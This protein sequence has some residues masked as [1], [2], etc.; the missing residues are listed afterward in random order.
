M[1]CIEW[2]EK[3][4]GSIDGTLRPDEKR[5][6]EAH[7]I[8]CPACRAQLESLQSLRA[9][10]RQL[11]SEIT[12]S[13]DLWSDIELRLSQPTPERARLLFASFHIWR[14][15]CGIALVLAAVGLWRW[16]ALRQPS[17]AWQI[18][19]VEGTPQINTRGFSGQANLRI[20]DWLETDA[21]ARAKVSVG[22]IGQVVVA[23]NSRVRMINA[24]A[25]NH[26]LE[27]ARGT[28]SALIWA[29]PRLFFVNTPSAVAVD[30]GC[31]YTLTVDD[32]GNGAL[33]V[34]SGYVAL[35]HD[36]RETIISAGQMCTTRR[37]AGPGTP[38]VDDA[39]P[40]LRRALDRFDF[41]HAPDALSEILTHVR[42]ADTLTLFSL[43][44]RVAPSARGEVFDVLARH[45]SPPTEV[46]K[47]GIVE[48]NRTMLDAWSRE[49]GLRGFS[50]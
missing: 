41:E 39:P 31:A 4:N 21:S 3:L 7:L 44:E 13:R 28:M 35:Q 48:G 11:P 9:A 25:E 30:L 19:A 43:L 10:T 5:A 15:A 32:H 1:N 24:S 17:T 23:P 40:A 14:I 2:K 46:T 33:H 16:T 37:D 49:L 6:L 20:G 22:T 27:L 26:R 38:F 29:P 34:T 12:P 8:V 47:V 45:Q 50:N 18:A 42:A 36:G